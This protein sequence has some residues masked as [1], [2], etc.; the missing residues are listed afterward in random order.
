MTKLTSLDLY[1]LTDTVQIVIGVSSGV[2]LRNVSVLATGASFTGV[3]VMINV[4]VSHKLEIGRAH[5]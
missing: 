2:V 5:V 1:I 4:A 3:I